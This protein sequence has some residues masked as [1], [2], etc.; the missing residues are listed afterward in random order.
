VW[1]AA[2]YIDSHYDAGNGIMIRD[3]WLHLPKRPG[4]GVLLDKAILGKPVMSFD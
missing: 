1:I 2:P 3:G 4:L